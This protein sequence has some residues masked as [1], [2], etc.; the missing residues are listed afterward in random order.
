MFFFLLTLC[1]NKQR[2]FYL[3]VPATYP[4]ELLA[5]VWDKLCLSPDRCSVGFY[6]RSLSW[7][8]H[9][10]HLW[11]HSDNIDPL[12]CV[13]SSLTC[14]L[15]IHNLSYSLSPSVSL[16]LSLFLCDGSQP[17]RKTDRLPPQVTGLLHWDQKLPRPSQD[18]RLLHPGAVRT[19]RLRHDCPLQGSMRGQM[20]SGVRW[21]DSSL[22]HRPGN[23][24]NPWTSF[25]PCLPLNP[26]VSC[27]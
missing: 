11:Y 16:S 22:S 10:K 7:D 9:S 17:A 25:N 13:F 12:I 23:G 8:M 14:A 1:W 3:R 18:T 4:G 27:F 15:I 26:G 20:S 21:P 19:I 6:N 5:F 24:H 2:C